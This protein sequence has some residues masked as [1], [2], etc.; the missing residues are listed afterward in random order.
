MSKK[1]IAKSYTENELRNLIAG[2]VRIVTPE[3]R[4]RILNLANASRI[5]NDIV[6]ALIFYETNYDPV[7]MVRNGH[8]CALGIRGK[9]IYFF[10][11]LGLFPDDQ[12]D[13]I[14]AKFRLQSN[15]NKRTLGNILY[16]L[17]N[18][19]FKVHYNDIPFQENDVNVNTCGRYCALFLNEGLESPGDPYVNMKK[20][21]N[22]YK[23]PE[24]NNYDNAIIRLN[25]Y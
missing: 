7:N 10:D 1:D 14:P 4:E 2:D 21:L 25:K 18:K 12:L 22:K 5:L 17:M 8:W 24:E 3:H 19:G 20:I 6:K 16:E 13:K 15:Q 23:Q 11:S 9:N